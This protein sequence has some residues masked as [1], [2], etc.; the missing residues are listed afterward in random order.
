MNPI[1]NTVF[2][3]LAV[4]LGTA[5]FVLSI[6]KVDMASDSLFMMLGM[7]VACLG[8]SMFDQKENKNN[9]EQN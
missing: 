4:G 7:A 2:K 8:L 5:V 3:A 1:F 6:M 9:S